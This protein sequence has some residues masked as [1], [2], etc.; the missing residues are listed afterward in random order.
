MTATKQE[1][2]VKRHR[3]IRSKLHGTAKKPR[4]VVYRS[5]LHTYVQAVDDDNNTILCGMTDKTL[6]AKG[7][8]SER[9]SQLGEEF[10]KKLNELKITSICFDRN[11]Y[12][13][14]GRVKAVADGIRNTGIKF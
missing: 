11:G 6:K 5:L 10:G 7:S 8:K 1:Q 14:H 9:A 12:K 3:R 2:R 13:Y 4:L